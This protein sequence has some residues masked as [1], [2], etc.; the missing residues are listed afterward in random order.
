LVAPE[1]VKYRAW[2]GSSQSLWQRYGVG[3]PLR[4]RAVGC[5]TAA[6]GSKNTPPPRSLHAFTVPTPGSTTCQPL[7]AP[8]QSISSFNPISLQSYPPSIYF[9]RPAAPLVPSPRFPPLCGPALPPVPPAPPVSADSR[10]IS[11]ITSH[12]RIPPRDA[13]RGATSQCVLCRVLP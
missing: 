1:E 13:R 5:S 10:L 3:S 7:E 4:V 6:T 9:P 12:R 8:P 2:Q 11:A